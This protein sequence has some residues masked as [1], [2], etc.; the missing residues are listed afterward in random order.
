VCFAVGRI[1]IDQEHNGASP[2]TGSARDGGS[3]VGSSLLQRVEMRGKRAHR[4]HQHHNQG[5]ANENF[6][7]EVSGKFEIEN[8]HK[9]F[10]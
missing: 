2:S 1:F 6:V 3:G 5:N 10:H 8:M 9:L 7:F 4:D